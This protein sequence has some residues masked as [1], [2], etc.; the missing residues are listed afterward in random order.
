MSRWVVESISFWKLMHLFTYWHSPDKENKRSFEHSLLLRASNTQKCS[1]V[2]YARGDSLG[3]I[4]SYW[5]ISSIIV[6][7][8]SHIENG[9]LLNT[10]LKGLSWFKRI[11]FSH[12]SFCVNVANYYI[13]K[14]VFDLLAQLVYRIIAYWLFHFHFQLT[15][16]FHSRPALVFALH[17]G[18]CSKCHRKPK[19]SVD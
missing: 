7:N 4:S 15:Q 19:V 11:S 1:T 17:R 2:G 14:F 9:T 13:V 8:F 10:C 6:L 12:T 18:F 3:R 5:I 16:T